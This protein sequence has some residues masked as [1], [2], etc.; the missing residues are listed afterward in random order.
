MLRPL[1]C[2]ATLVASHA[3]A[4]PGCPETA[5]LETEQIKTMIAT[6]G[7]AGADPIDQ[8][9]AFETLRCADSKLMRD[10]TFRA[11]LRSPNDIIRAEAVFRALADRKSIL[12]MLGAE[13]LDDRAR[14]FVEKTPRM[15]YDNTF[16][17]AGLRC[18]GIFYDTCQ[19][20]YA[21]VVTRNEVTL[22]FNKD[23]IVLKSTPDGRLRGTFT[24]GQIE[25]PAEIEVY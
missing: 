19:P 14:A 17:D 22:R 23:V 18:I 2:A 25:L 9:A 21:I 3:F 20:G 13:E 4:D 12:V 24:N 10:Q 11:A 1:A 8:I 5:T 6:I 7:D 15:I 16:V